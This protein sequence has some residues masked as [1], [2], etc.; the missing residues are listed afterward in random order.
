MMFMGNTDSI[1]VV[2]ADDGVQEGDEFGDE[3]D[4]LKN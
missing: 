4:H 2:R 1:S 3:Q